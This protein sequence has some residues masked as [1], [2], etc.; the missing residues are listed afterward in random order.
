MWAHGEGGSENHKKGYCSDGVKQKPA[1]VDGVIDELPPW[2]Q[3]NKIFTKGT[4]FWPKRF[5]RMVRELYDVVTEGGYRLGG[6]KTMEFAAFAEMLRLCLVVIPA[7]A[8]Q[9]SLVR[10]KL[11]RGFQLGEQPGSPSDI[12]EV[13]GIKY[14]H[15]TYLSEPAFQEE[16]SSIPPAVR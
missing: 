8:T 15:V 10:F 7:T 5:A 13:D 14:L 4:H 1:A 6:P 12:V 3:P 16:R 11:Y 2:P 9:T